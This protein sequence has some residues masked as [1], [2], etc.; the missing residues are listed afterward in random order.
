MAPVPWF[1]PRPW[2]VPGRQRFAAAANT[3]TAQP[4][5]GLNPAFNQDGNILIADQFNN[6]VIL[7]NHAKHML[8]SYGLPL[9]GGGA[10]G[11]NVGYDLNTTQNGL[12]SPYDAKIIG[13]Y[14]GLTAPVA[15]ENHGSY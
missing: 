10:I 5:F 14:T 8:A 13:D 4:Y 6:R 3:A 12:Y 15:S 9:D 11:N 1:V 7:V 2:P